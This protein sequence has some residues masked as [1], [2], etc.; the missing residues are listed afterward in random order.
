VVRA[1]SAGS[2][3]TRSPA[4][5][6]SRWSI[7]AVRPLPARPVQVREARTWCAAA[8]SDAE[9]IAGRIVEYGSAVEAATWWGRHD[10]GAA[11]ARSPGAGSLATQAGVPENDHGRI[12][13]AGTRRSARLVTGQQQS[14]D[15]HYVLL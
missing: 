9:K 14:L 13:A 11:A 10:A 1:H 15:V 12:L 6:A 2:V 3:S 4:S 7:K 8:S 5:G